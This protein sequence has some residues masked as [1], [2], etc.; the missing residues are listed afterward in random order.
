MMKYRKKPIIVEAYQTEYEVDINTSNGLRHAS[1]GDFIITG[2][3]GEKYPCKPNIFA[4]T[5]EPIEDEKEVYVVED[6]KAAVVPCKSIFIDNYGIKIFFNKED[7]EK[8]VRE[9]L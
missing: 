1:I 2:E 3:N 4:Q 6:G 8:A 9:E 5:Y 7:A